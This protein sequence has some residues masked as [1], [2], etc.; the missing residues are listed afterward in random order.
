M[1]SIIISFSLVLLC[2]LSDNSVSSSTILEVASIPSSQ[3]YNDDTPTNTSTSTYSNTILQQSTSVQDSYVKASPLSVAAVCNDGIV[4][5]SL[6]YNV[7]IDIDEE[8]DVEMT[9]SSSTTANEEEEDNNTELAS[10]KA[11]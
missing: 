7:D 8:K 9:S 4:M 5:I 3:P 6:H 1:N 10:E 2:C 11:Q